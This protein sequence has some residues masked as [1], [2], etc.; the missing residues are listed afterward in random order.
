MLGD[1]N[2][3][4]LNHGAFREQNEEFRCF[5]VVC[6]CSGAGDSSSIFVLGEE[7]I[8]VCGGFEVKQR[9]EVS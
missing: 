9:K 5:G 2:E 1:K 7:S 6:F 8:I 3:F 4:L